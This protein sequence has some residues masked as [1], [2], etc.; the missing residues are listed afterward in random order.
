MYSLTLFIQHPPWAR[1]TWSQERKGWELRPC[2]LVPLLTQ[3]IPPGPVIL[4]PTVICGRRIVNI[5]YLTILKLSIS[6]YRGKINNLTS[7]AGNFP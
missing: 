4:A 6:P 7:N 1:H 5:F 3:W 2:S